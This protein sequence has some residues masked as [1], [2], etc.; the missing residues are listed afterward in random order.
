MKKK[1]KKTVF[2]KE[3]LSKCLK[4]LYFIPMHFQKTVSNVNTF[5]FHPFI[6]FPLFLSSFI[7][8]KY[9]YFIDV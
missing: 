6:F 3:Q 4:T 2:K 1:W 7:T 9:V 8:N 5:A